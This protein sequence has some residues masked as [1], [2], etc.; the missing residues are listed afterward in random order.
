[1]K[2]KQVSRPRESNSDST[3]SS[4]SLF[5]C[6]TTLSEKKHFLILLNVTY[7]SLLLQERCL[8][9]TAWWQKKKHQQQHAKHWEEVGF[10]SPNRRKSSGESGKDE[11]ARKTI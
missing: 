6:L 5:Q 10:S 8:S 1:M 4:G 3:T 7:E 9:R 2:L 11:S